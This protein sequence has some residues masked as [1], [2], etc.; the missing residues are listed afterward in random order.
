MILAL[1]R[2]TL[3]RLRAPR[4][5]LTLGAW[6]VLALGFALAARSRDAAHGADHVLVD[7][8][9]ALILPLIAYTLVGAVV[10]GRTL[11]RSTAPLVSF[12]AAPSRAASVTVVIAM[13]TCAAI[14]AAVGAIVAVVAHGISDPPAGGDALASAYAGALGGAAYASWFA[15]GSTFGKRGGGRTLLLVVDWL[16]GL[17]HGVIALLTPRAHLRNLLGGAPAMGWSERASAVALLVLAA[18][19]ALGAITRSRRP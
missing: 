16:V 15:L 5:W 1:S 13:V 10:G 7:A 3:A 12:G 6:S 17:G 14:A 9:G 18:A 4:A 19:F 8:F 2:P 11:A